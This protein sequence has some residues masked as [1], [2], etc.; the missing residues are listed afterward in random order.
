MHT[1]NIKRLIL[2]KIRVA[3]WAML[4]GRPGKVLSSSTIISRTDRLYSTF[5]KLSSHKR[6]DDGVEKN[7]NELERIKNA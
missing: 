3:G 4:Y 7:C 6:Q 1:I 5:R 2:I